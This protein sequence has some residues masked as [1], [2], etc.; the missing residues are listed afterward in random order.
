MSL[1]GFQQALV[2]LTLAPDSIRA[3]RRGEVDALDI[4]DLTARE[5]ARL[6]DVAGQPGVAMNCALA[7][8]NR[9][10]LIVAAFP[11]S[12]VLLK[13]LLPR[14]LDELWERHRPDNYQ[15]FGEE[16]AFAVFIARKIERGEIVCEYLAE[17][18]EYEIACQTLARRRETSDEG[19]VDL[20]AVVEFLHSPDQLLSSLGRN[21]APPSGLP[22]GIFRMRIRLSEAGFRL[23]ALS[24]SSEAAQPFSRISRP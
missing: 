4:Y 10:E 17:I 16:D 14:L 6:L 23:E 1:K 11:M 9:L 18:F 13:P 22:C 7:R 24:D 15:L 21:V 2:D 19:T 3:L 20:E 5:R 8:G 12:C